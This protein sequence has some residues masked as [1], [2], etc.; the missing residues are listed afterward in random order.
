MKYVTAEFAVGVNQAVCGSSSSVNSTES[1]LSAVGIQQWYMNN[2]KLQSSALLRSLIL[3]HPFKDG[4]KRT[5]YIC[6]CYLLN[7]DKSDDE[8]ERF[9]IEIA[10]GDIKTPEMISRYLY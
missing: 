7:I 2:L 5:A 3:N 9:L 8:I 6:A 10:K 1:L 4:N